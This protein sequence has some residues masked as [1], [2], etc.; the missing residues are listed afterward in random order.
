MGHTKF[1]LQGFSNGASSSFCYLKIIGAM[2]FAL[3]PLSQAE[4]QNILFYPFP[5]VT[6]V[7]TENNS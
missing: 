2:S 3:M 7:A 4:F 5:M 6:D 1:I